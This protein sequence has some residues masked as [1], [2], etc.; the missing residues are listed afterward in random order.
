MSDRIG[1]TSI[2][3]E[4]PP[5]E[6]NKLDEIFESITSAMCDAIHRE[7]FALAMER[8]N[9]VV[10]LLELFHMCEDLENLDGL[11]H[12][13]NIFRT[14]FLLNKPSLLTIMFHDDNILS[15]V[16]CL[17][18]EPNKLHPVQHRKYLRQTSHHREV[19][20]FDNPQLMAKIH[21]TYRVQY[22][23]DVILP[24][25]SLFEENMM[26]ALNSFVLF[27]K[28]EIVN[29]I[30]VGV[31]KKSQILVVVM[32]SVIFRWSRLLEPCAC[33]ACLRHA[34]SSFHRQLID[35]R[36]CCNHIC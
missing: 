8:D 25:P 31:V 5:C 20:P 1:N 10:K 16:G 26:S 2:S 9:Y 7:A 3:I 24:T 4:L 15:V 12:L 30:Q 35:H 36:L 14:M 18:Y 21:Q 23:Q 27:N 29:C 11:H 22:I 17:E 28:T 13:Y 33:N 6:L 19:L 32:F 34:Q